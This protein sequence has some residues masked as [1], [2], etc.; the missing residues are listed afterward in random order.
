VNGSFVRAS[1]VGGKRPDSLIASVEGASKTVGTVAGTLH[2]SFTEAKRNGV[3]EI[4]RSVPMNGVSRVSPLH[5]T[6]RNQRTQGGKMISKNKTVLLRRSAIALMAMGWFL[7]HAS[8]GEAQTTTFDPAK[9]QKGLAIAPVPL[10]TQ[11]KDMNLVGYGSYL[12]N[13]IGDCN[14]CHSAGPQTE[15]AVGGNPYMSQHPTVV[16]PATYLAGGQDFG[17][18]PDPTGPFPHIISRNLTPNSTGLPEGGNSFDTFV[19]IMRTGIDTDKAHPTCMGPP[20]GKCIPAPF[21]GELLQVMPWPTLQNMTDDDLL[22]IYTYLSAIPC[23]EGGPG[24][25]ANRCVAAAKTAA[26]AGPKNGTANSSEVR[27]DGS[28]STSSDGKP[29]KYQWSIPKGSPSAAI[30]Q[31]TTATPSVQFS[32][33]N[34]LYTFLLTVTDSSGNSATDIA[35][36]LFNG[37]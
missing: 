7:V 3:A 19:Q 20:D 26:I 34:V 10:N 36:V 28:M 29:L 18:F 35:T 12:V 30:Y 17:A 5:S 24:E 11:G 2:R 31:G 16:N 13:A 21:N 15:Y 33:R 32:Q 6:F 1:E 22:A 25:P 9:V 27:L 37:N 14:G 4:K 23:V 8:N